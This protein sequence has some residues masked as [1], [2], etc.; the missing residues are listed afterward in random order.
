MITKEEAKNKLRKA[1][2]SVVD[3]NSVLTIL[4][5]ENASIKNTVKSVKELLLKIDYQA[6][7]GVK[8]HSGSAETDGEAQ[9]SEQTDELMDDEVADALMEDE[10]ADELTDDGVDDAFAADTSDMA[11]DKLAEM[12]D[13]SSSKKSLETKK[14]T[15]NTS[16]KTDSKRDASKRDVSKDT[17]S[18][19]TTA[20]KENL[21]KEDFLDEEDDY[22]DDEDEN[23]DELNKVKLDDLDMDMMLNEDSIQ[24]SLE[25]FGLM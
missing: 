2:Y 14:S 23:L 15:P 1:G 24:F 4:I 9:D 25:D 6:S 17:A 20:K 8:Q 3:D 5:S 12:M 7:F 13:D 22:L 10:Q 11:D 18:K 21:N 16:K 19:K